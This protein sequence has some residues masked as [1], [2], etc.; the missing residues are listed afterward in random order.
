[1]L[2]T[3]GQTTVTLPCMHAEGVL[4]CMGYDGCGSEDVRGYLDVVTSLQALQ[5]C[6]WWR[7][8]TELGIIR[9]FLF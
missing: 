3:Q 2:Y 1:M 8:Y 6:T 9:S 7:R 4:H 5:S